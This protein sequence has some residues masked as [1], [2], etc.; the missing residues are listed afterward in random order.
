M[1]EFEFQRT[2]VLHIHALHTVT[3]QTTSTDEDCGMWL[4]GP[5]KPSKWTLNQDCQRLC[6]QNQK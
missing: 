4:K 3:R 1:N 6:F 2:S 5:E